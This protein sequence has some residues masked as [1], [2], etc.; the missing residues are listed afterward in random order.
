MKNKCVFFFLIRDLDVGLAVIGGILERVV[1]IG[2]RV[3][4]GALLS[5][6]LSSE[7]RRSWRGSSIHYRCDI[8]GHRS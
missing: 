2:R 6:K 7:T 1:D 3:V 8:L 4:V 5:K